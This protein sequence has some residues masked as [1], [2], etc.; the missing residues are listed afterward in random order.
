MSKIITKVKTP[1]V[2]EI[3]KVTKILD[4]NKTIATNEKAMQE[5][6]IV[7]S[8]QLEQLGFKFLDS[9]LSREVY[10]NDIKTIVIKVS[11]KQFYNDK[12]QN[13]VEVKNYLKASRKI[14]KFLLPILA[15]ADD[16]SWI[17]VPYAEDVR[18]KD[19]VLKEFEKKLEEDKVT[20]EDYGARNCGIFNNKVYIRDYGLE[21]F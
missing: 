9:G 11:A 4:T 7:L 8:E 13:E 2:E 19:K 15:Y 20:F 16:Y 1:E 17:I 6:A 18:Y 3:T 21:D 14:K 5:K 10:T 12:N